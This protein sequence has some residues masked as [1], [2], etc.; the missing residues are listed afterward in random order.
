[1]TCSPACNSASTDIFAFG[2][3]PDAIGRTIGAMTTLW[4]APWRAW[5]ALALEAMD[6]RNHPL[7]GFSP[8][9]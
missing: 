4:M 1:M 6:M 9:V 8:R 7:P 2:G 3:D 5:C